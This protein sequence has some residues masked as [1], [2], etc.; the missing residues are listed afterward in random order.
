M[1]LNINIKSIISSYYKYTIKQM[2][3]FKKSWK[4]N[5]N[6][7]NR[8]FH[9]DMKDYFEDCY[10]CNDNS[11]YNRECIKFYYSLHVINSKKLE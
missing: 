4:E 6:K 3:E 9:C 1:D 10:I 5:I 2:N 7:V 8:L 11:H